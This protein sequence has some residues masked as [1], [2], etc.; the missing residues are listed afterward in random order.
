MN[1]LLAFSDVLSISGITAVICGCFL[2]ATIGYLL[3]RI[4]V[5]GVSLG[6][7][8]VFLVAI[9]FGFLF[10]IP[11]LKDLDFLKN[12]YIPDSSATAYKYYNEIDSLGLILFVTAVGYIAGPTFFRNLKKNA[13]SYVL[14]GAIIILSGV[15]VAVGFAFLPDIGSGFSA[16]ILSG[17]LTST[18]AFSAAEEAAKAAGQD[19]AMVALGH[20]IA[21]PFGVVGVVLFVQL[22]P[23]IMKANKEE[24]IAK[25]LS[26]STG[27]EKAEE[28]K[29]FSIDE[30]GLAAFG[31]AVVLGII[32]GKLTVTIGSLKFNLGTTGGPLIVALIFGHFGRIGKISL[33]VPEHTLKVFR[34][35]GLMLFLIGA[36][37]R[38][39]VSLLEKIL[40]GN[41]DPMLILWGFI[42]GAIMTVV[43]MIIG[44]FFAKNV[45]KLPLFNNLGSITGGMTSTPALGSLCQ[46]SGTDNV[47]GAYAATYP[48]ALILIVIASNLIVTLI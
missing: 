47:A 22:V 23:K 36:G 5:K 35:F 9:G 4:T 42:A 11:G 13:T 38:G 45:L 30:F 15:L 46:V 25:M 28:K 12:F 7:A 48:I 8:G 34:E 39:G 31:L 33:K 18:P 17:A 1:S 26:V 2:I 44:F 21:Y 32:L 20:A 43:P 29:L 6:T 41:F 10:A 37:V 16:G 19:V 40:A 27:E 14:L 3:G 24:E